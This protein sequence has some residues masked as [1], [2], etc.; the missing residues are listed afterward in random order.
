MSIPVQCEHCFKKYNAPDSMAGKKIKCRNCG[1]VFSVPGGEQDEL[2]LSA[3]QAEE[4]AAG[5]G[6]DDVMSGSSMGSVAGASHRSGAGMAGQRI[7]SDPSKG[8]AH[9][10]ARTG[11]AGD[12]P[13]ASDAHDDGPPRRK[14]IPFDFPGAAVLDNLAPIVLIVLGLGWLALMAF[15]SNDTGVPW[16]GMLRMGLYVLLYIALAFPLCYAAVKWAAKASRFALPPSPALR[17]FG[18]FAV[19]FASL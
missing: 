2:D 10:R 6:G 19:P 15:N 13:I 3:L 11:D 17:A 18:A 5:G 1:K 7:G 8:I 16:V 12:I 14:S 9:K 4:A